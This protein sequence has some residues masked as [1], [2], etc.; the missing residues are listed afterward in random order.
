MGYLL[1]CPFR[2]FL[3][4][5]KRIL[6]PHVRPGMKVVEPGCG[7]GFFS[8]P[9]A[10]MVGPKGRV[11]CVDLQKPMIKRLLRRAQKAGLA[12]RV[13]A[14]VCSAG[15]LGLERWCGTIDLV[16]AIHVIHEVPDAPA[17]LSQVHEVLRPSARLLVLEPKGHVTTQAFHLTLA[18]AREA[19]FKELEP[20]KLRREHTALLEKRYGSEAAQSRT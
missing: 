7:M 3:E 17:F 10:R 12:D 11:I 15:N 9:L 4:N 1:C 16:T 5:P 13:E 2:R 20:P 6:G 18:R 14:L 8:L 19:G